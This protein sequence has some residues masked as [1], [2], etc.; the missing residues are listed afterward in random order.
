MEHLFSVHYVYLTCL[1]T[2]D[3]SCC[4]YRPIYCSKPNCLPL[5]SDLYI[6]WRTN[7]HYSC[8]P[9]NLQAC[10]SHTTHHITGT[11]FVFTGYYLFCQTLA[12]TAING[13]PVNLYSMDQVS[14]PCGINKDGGF[15][16]KENWSSWFQSRKMW[17]ENLIYLILHNLHKFWLEGC[18][19]V[20][21]DQ[22]LEV[23]AS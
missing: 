19:I 11:Y 7:I 9:L 10:Y 5:L 20:F 18:I 22:C 1:V 2:A 6:S 15:R 4:F 3:C 16:Y 13:T 17:E 23:R 21:S 14:N 12:L 8:L